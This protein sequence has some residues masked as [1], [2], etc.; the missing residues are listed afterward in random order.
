MNDI[1]PLPKASTLQR[2]LVLQIAQLIRDNNL[3]E[4]GHVTEGVLADTLNVSRTPTRAALAHLASLGILEPTGARRGF[5]VVANEEQIQSV[6]Q[7][8]EA[9]DEADA[10]Y[11]QIGEDYMRHKLPDQFSEADIMRIYGTS[12]RVLLRVLQRLTSD[13]VI[14]RNP[15]YG[16]RFATMLRSVE[17][18][19]DSY[20]F[21][22]ATEPAS[23]L[24]INFEL[25]EAW[26]NRTR[27]AHE[28]VLK[29]P[30]E[31]VSQPHLF[32]I[33]ADFHL[34]LARCSNNVFFVQSMEMQNQA[35]RFQVY[36]WVYGDERIYE[37][38][39]EH[40]AI[41]DAV[42]SGD[43][44]WAADLMRRHLEI[45]CRLKPPEDD[46]SWTAG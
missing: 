31:K 21:R 26:A 1:A 17:S 34:G 37:S 4:G 41:L 8:G 10:L 9:P 32:E 44:A 40:L 6:I 29:T 2:K 20:R 42:T 7:E 24:Q 28:A 27:F 15:G 18:H 36:D 35:R 33:N 12:R 23:L 13:R 5:K 22:M 14:E 19:D 11:M 38:C 45:S 3:T 46:G 25:D 30:A 16:W 39:R 43:N